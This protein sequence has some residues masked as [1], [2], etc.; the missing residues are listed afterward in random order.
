MKPL[1]K[2]LLSLTVS[3]TMLLGLAA[4]GSSGTESSSSTATAESSA[5]KTSLTIVTDSDLGNMSPF[6]SGNSFAYFQDQVYESLFRLGYN[7]EMT[8]VLAESWDQES[9]THYIFHLREGV[10]DSAG[11]PVTA[12]DVLYSI[13]LYAQDATYKQY[14]EHIDLEKT[15]APDDTTLDLYFADTYAFAFT[16]L[17][18]VRVVTQ[19]AWEASGDGMITDPVGSGPYKLDEYVSGSYFTLSYNENYWGDEPAIK[20][21]RFN[22]VSEP[23]QRTTQLETGVA[24]LVMNLQASDVAYIDDMDNFDVTSH[25]SYQSMTMFFNM[26]PVSAMS[27]KELRQAVCYS[28]DNASINAAAYGGY[29]IPSKTLFSSAMLDY[30]DDMASEMYTTSDPAKAAELIAASGKAGST[31]HIATDGSAQETTIAEMLQSNLLENGIDVVI[32]SYDPATIWSVATDTSKWDLL[33]MIASTPA[34][35][36]LGEMNAFLNNLNFSHWSG[37]SFDKVSALMT[38]GTN[39]VDEAQRLEITKQ[40]LDIVTEEVPAYAFVEIAQNFAY[41]TSLNFQVWDQ[42]S[43]YVAD[44]Q[45]S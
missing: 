9:D 12:Q 44:L 7:M 39:T 37:E 21:V 1:T 32:D 38:E 35:Y 6:G 8:P 15:T 28:V 45:F 19:A 20:N 11:N 22:I 18:G 43:V 26:D 3:A 14:V 5:G 17:A 23:S 31:I 33:L 42:A 2:R 29:C 13:K 34:G 27:S 25:A 30:T 41:N 4:C 40:V 24:D 36:G 10:T 16:Q